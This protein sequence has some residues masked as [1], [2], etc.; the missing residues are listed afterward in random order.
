LR[1]RA[2][3]GERAGPSSR[4]PPS[5]RAPASTRAGG[6]G[7]LSDTVAAARRPG[8]TA[9]LAQR[10]GSGVDSGAKRVLQR[11]RLAVGATGRCR[12]CSRRGSRLRAGLRLR[13]RAQRARRRAAA[14][15]LSSRRAGGRAGH[16]LPGTGRWGRGFPS[17]P[18]DAAARHFDRR[19]LDRRAVE[20]LKLVLGRN[21]RAAGCERKVGPF[22]SGLL[23]S[24]LPL[25]VFGEE[26][27]WCERRGW[28]DRRDAHHPLGLKMGGYHLHVSV[29]ARAE[30]IGAHSPT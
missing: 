12:R 19:K 16:R 30:D 7:A 29:H 27:R 11:K 1:R 17:A 20:H 8:R 4:P 23:E 26:P 18:C 3:F 15:D 6:R 2:R 22:C 5:R 10:C 25:H 13:W 14:H 9:C 24:Q 28:R 21:G